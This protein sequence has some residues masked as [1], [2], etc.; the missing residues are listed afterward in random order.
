MGGPYTHGP[1]LDLPLD[2][3]RTDFSSFP[4]LLKKALDSILVRVRAFFKICS[5]IEIPAFVSDSSDAEQFEFRSL[6]FLT[7][8]RNCFAKERTR[9]SMI[10]KRMWVCFDC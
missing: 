7:G 4:S 1:P 6:D 3:Y 8:K 2:Q 5:V 10:I 9:Q